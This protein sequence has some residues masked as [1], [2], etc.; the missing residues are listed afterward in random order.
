MK[1]KAPEDLLEDTTVHEGC[2]MVK[3]LS[4]I[5]LVALASG[6]VTGVGFLMMSGDIVAAVGSFNLIWCYVIGMVAELVA[7][8][9]T[10]TVA[11][12]YPSAGS[13]AT[14]ARKI[15]G[16]D[17]LGFL[18]AVALCLG[19]IAING[20][21]LMALGRYIYYVM[22][23]VHYYWWGLII[24]AIFT[25]I[26]LFGVSTTSRTQSFLGI[27]MWSSLL[28][29][30]IAVITSG[31]ADITYW[32]V[33]KESSSLT[34]WMTAIFFGVYCYVGFVTILPAAEETSAPERQIPAAMI[35]GVFITAFLYI[36]GGL[37]II[38]LRPEN[39]LLSLS[40]GGPLAS[41][42]V[43]AMEVLWD[44]KGAIFMNFTAIATALTTANAC[45][46]GG[47]RMLY[48]MARE[49]QL[50]EAFRRIHPKRKTPTVPIL[51]TGVFVLFCVFSGAI[52]VISVMANFVFF[53]L[54]IV[55]SIAS[56]KNLSRIKK[57]G[58]KYREE[59][60]FYVPGG[61]F[62]PV[63]SIIM[64]SGLTVVTF[65]ST[66]DVVMGGSIVVI[67]FAVCWIY[68]IW[69]KNYNLR[70]GID[71]VAEAALHESHPSDWKS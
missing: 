22:P 4:F 61:R 25:V 63:L 34:E 40:R 45:I 15:I 68:Y 36:A 48:G 24:T 14:Y 59:I 58:K 32:Q 39:E 1:E 17:I 67:F 42:W 70:Q 65:L 62:W 46:Y 41:V 20:S 27:G 50:P 19:M 53:P 47:A 26:N 16:S 57:Q 64:S 9:A 52:R 37:A 5:G 69:W 60:P 43:R 13:V 10:A 7:M 51:A 28:A 12:S 8:L 23:Q 29:V 11:S 56:F 6:T 2:R 66:S 30:P 55:I 21:E 35:T 31:K 33:L 49:R 3:G 44:G 38:S 54:W 71:I 18:S